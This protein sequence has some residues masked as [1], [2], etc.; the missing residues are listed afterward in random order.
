MRQNGTTVPFNF[1]LVATKMRKLHLLCVVFIILLGCSARYKVGDETFGSSSEALQRQNEKLS[2][3]LDG[4]TPTDNPVHGSAL[5]LIPSDVEIHKNYI[6]FG[7]KASKIQKEQLDWLITSVKN[8]FQ[9]QAN[10]IRKRGIFD[11]VSVERHKGNPASFSIGDYD[12]MVFADVDGWFI[13]GK[14]NPKP[15][16]IITADKSIDIDARILA[17]LD[18][19]SQQA[20]A[21]RSQ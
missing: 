21:L 18:L 4:I 20:K 3:S 9:A 1:K 5:V 10:A 17:F 8:G 15:F 13:K 14:G 12:F 11:S 19:L 7:S 6:L 16:P 2:H